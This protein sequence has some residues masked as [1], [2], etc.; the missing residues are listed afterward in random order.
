MA[1]KFAQVVVV[2][3]IEWKLLKDGHDGWAWALAGTTWAVQG[4]LIAHNYHVKRQQEQE[5]EQN[6]RIVVPAKLV[7]LMP[8]RV[9]LAVGPGSIGVGVSW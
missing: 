9:S 5:A 6:S 8:T 3:G 4:A 2:T 1:L 7:P